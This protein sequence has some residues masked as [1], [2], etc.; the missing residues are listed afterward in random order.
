MQTSTGLV[1]EIVLR[2]DRLQAA[3]ITCP[4]ASLPGPGQYLSAWSIEDPLEPLATTLF[5]GEL[6][7]D[8]FLAL[9]PLP[10]AWQPGT[11]LALRGP[12][13]HGFSPP[14]TAH[15]VALAAL[16]Q[17]CGRLIPLAYQALQHGAAVALFTDAWLPSLPA[18]MEANPLSN[19][20]EAIAWADYLAVDVNSIT[21][22]K[23]RKMLGL[24]S[25]DHLPCPA[26]ALFHVE[27]PCS[28][29]AACGACWVPA[30]HGILQA[31]SDGPVF[32]LNELEW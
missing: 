9:P 19:L 10:A 1:Q 29:L 23:L 24:Q 31:C 15:R 3:W 25:G 6:L 8:R 16:G 5:A 20:S 14:D 4:P 2:S 32:A 26:Q 30:R 13:G 22:P 18:A 17:S 21:L 7:E 11:R 28:G 12:L 27:L